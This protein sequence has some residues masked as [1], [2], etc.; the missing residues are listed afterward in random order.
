MSRYPYAA[1]MSH[2]VNLYSL[3]Q[4]QDLC[5]FHM[6]AA[7]LFHGNTTEFNTAITKIPCKCNVETPA[8]T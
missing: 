7:I 8:L 5:M 6:E 3:H 4:W 1:H 2:L